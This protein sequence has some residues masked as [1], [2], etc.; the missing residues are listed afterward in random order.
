MQSIFEKLKNIQSF[1]YEYVKKKI[2]IFVTFEIHLQLNNRILK[3]HLPNGFQ[4]MKNFKNIIELKE[5]IFTIF[6]CVKNKT[7]LLIYI[8][9]FTDND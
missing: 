9:K 1:L 2:K 6:K 3:F 7:K 4:K 5:I 8:Y